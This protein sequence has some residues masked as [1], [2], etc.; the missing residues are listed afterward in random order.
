[1]AEILR[2]QAEVARDEELSCGHITTSS[3]G[4]ICD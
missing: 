1:M 4:S 2:L 3:S